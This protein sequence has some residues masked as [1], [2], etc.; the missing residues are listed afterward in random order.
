MSGERVKG[1]SERGGEEEEETE[2][3]RGRVIIGKKCRSKNTLTHTHAGITFISAHH[4]NTFHDG[5]TLKRQ[6]E[7]IIT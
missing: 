6:S 3:E 2:E 5:H 1:E 4:T 7:K